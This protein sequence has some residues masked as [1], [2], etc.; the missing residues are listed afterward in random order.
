M[1]ITDAE[2]IIHSHIAELKDT[3]CSLSHHLNKKG[4]LIVHLNNVMSIAKEYFPN[5]ET[6][7]A[8]AL[9]HDIGKARVYKFDA[10]II[11]FVS[12]VDHV[13]HTMDMIKESNYDLTPEECIALKMHHG[14]WSSFKGIDMNELACKLHFVDHIGT[15]RESA[16]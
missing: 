14:G 3:P 8:L 6:L 1:K 4:G 2:K 9:V 15:L 7:I 16:H 5:D 10:D 13:I 11:R 12:R